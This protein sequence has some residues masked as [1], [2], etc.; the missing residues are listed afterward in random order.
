MSDQ[1]EP[2]A[3]DNTLSN[4]RLCI[5]DMGGVMVDGHDVTPRIAE[6]LGVPLAE[7][8][9]Q[10]RAASD[11]DLH[12]GTVAP[13]RY[14]SRFSQLTGIEVQGD[15]W[16]EFF[17]PIRRPP[18]YDLVE[19]LKRSGIRVVAGTNTIDVHYAIHRDGGDYAVFDTVY[20]SN[21]MHVSKPDQAFWRHILNA[22]GVEPGQALFVDD[23][24]E[25][26]AAA[27]AVGLHAV[28]FVTAEQ[29]ISEVE[30]AFGLTPA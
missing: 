8:L 30:R 3:T 2:N 12:D 6:R 20:A 24:P 14:W 10:L 19:R 25:N 15:P 17:K 5:F 27:A 1:R 4:L 21:L 11:V 22:E 23:L 7:L 13:D 9:P 16:A 26:V 29:V 18:M 28:P